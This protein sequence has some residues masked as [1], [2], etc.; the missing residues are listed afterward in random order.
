MLA[1]TVFQA[2][3]Q[4]IPC[5]EYISLIIRIRLHHPFNFFLPLN[6]PKQKPARFYLTF[7]VIVI[8]LNLLILNE[9]SQHMME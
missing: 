1:D 9:R 6:F 8:L 7:D 2:K 3:S 5:T 4:L